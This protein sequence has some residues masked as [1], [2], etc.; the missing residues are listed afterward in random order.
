MPGYIR[1]DV[2][3]ATHRLPLDGFLYNFVFLI[4][5][6]SVDEKNL[7]GNLRTVRELKRMVWESKLPIPVVEQSKMRV[8]CRSLAGVAGLNH[9]GDMDVCI[10]CFK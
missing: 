6:K 4:L 9:A 5:L 3:H 2:L 7:Y 8:C 1:Y 10:V